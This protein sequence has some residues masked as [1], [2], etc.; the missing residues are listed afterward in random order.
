MK[1]EVK[2][3]RWVLIALAIPGLILACCVVVPICVFVAFK[4]DPLNAPEDVIAGRLAAMPEKAQAEY[5]SSVLSDTGKH[6]GDSSGQVNVLLALEYAQAHGIRLVYDMNLVLPFAGDQFL[7]K[8]DQP[9]Y[10]EPAQIIAARILMHS[11]RADVV[12]HAFEVHRSNKNAFARLCKFV[13]RG[14]PVDRVYLDARAKYCN[15]TR[16][17]L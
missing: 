14:E 1:R 9:S 13:E 3:P 5:I 15:A 6:A 2:I 16:D 17:T 7:D 8:Y 4:L 10:E 12:D 11:G